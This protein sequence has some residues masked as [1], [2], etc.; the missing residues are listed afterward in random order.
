ML[1]Y[2]KVFI[3]VLGKLLDLIDC[4]LLEVL[5]I[6]VADNSLE[7][8]QL[9]PRNFFFVG[10]LLL[11]LDEEF[12]IERLDVLVGY[13][14]LYLFQ[15]EVEYLFLGLVLEEQGWVDLGDFLVDEGEFL[16]RDGLVLIDL[17]LLLQELSQL[18]HIL[19]HSRRT[20]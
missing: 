7:K 8:C 14:A 19:V 4:D 11:L 9:E 1:K 5:A 12:L 6:E 18:R 17:A 15:H 3:L 13:A 2:F 10:K 16:E 20:R